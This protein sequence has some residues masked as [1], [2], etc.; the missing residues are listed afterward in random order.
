MRTYSIHIRR[1]GLNA[2]PD[3]AVIKE[4]F[5]WP[6]FLFSGLWALW[7]RLWLVALGTFLVLGLVLSLPWLIGGTEL[8]QAILSFG[9][10]VIFGMLANDIRRWYLGRADFVEV[11]IYIGHTSD[12]ALFAYLSEAQIPSETN[13]AGRI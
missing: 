2:E 3:F 5:S 1:Q 4:G 7:C 13:A 11:G 6:A 9:S 12:E 8:D 10:F